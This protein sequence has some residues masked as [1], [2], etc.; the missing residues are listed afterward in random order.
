M[1]KLTIRRVW[2]PRGPVRRRG[3]FVLVVEGADDGCGAAGDLEAVT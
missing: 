3:R 1:G 2:C